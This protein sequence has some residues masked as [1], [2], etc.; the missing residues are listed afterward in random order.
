M[1]IKSNVTP[2]QNAQL[3]QNVYHQMLFVI[4]S[5][6]LFRLLFFQ[7]FPF[8]LRI[9][10]SHSFLIH[11]YLYWINNGCDWDS[12]LQGRPIYPNWCE[13]ILHIACKDWDI[14]LFLFLFP[15]RHF[16]CE[17][18]SYWWLWINQFLYRPFSMTAI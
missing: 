18:H 12:K 4:R 5:H 11:K 9:L 10:S 15:K 2:M 16:F 6:L 8:F 1:V 7:G 14:F 3:S 13:N 17:R